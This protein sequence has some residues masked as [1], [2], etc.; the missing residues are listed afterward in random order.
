MTVTI[1]ERNKFCP[2]D[3][4]HRSGKMFKSGAIDG[5]TKHQVKILPV[6]PFVQSQQRGS[7]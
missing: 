6:H 7:L 2:S 5:K 3:L 1:D 4:S